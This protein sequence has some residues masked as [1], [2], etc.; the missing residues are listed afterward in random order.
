MALALH[1]Q[2][3]QYPK[4]V[5]SAAH[6]YGCPPRRAGGAV[7]GSGRIRTPSVAGDSPW[8]NAGTMH[9]TLCFVSVESVHVSN[10][11]PW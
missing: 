6:R 5:Q 10:R 9:P 8:Q 2:C 7:P 11:V 3:F 4:I 1:T